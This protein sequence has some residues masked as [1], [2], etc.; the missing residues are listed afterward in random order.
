MA[1]RTFSLNEW[2]FKNQSRYYFQG[3]KRTKHLL[4]DLET[5]DYDKY[6]REFVIGIQ[7]YLHHERFQENASKWR[8]TR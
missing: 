5:L 6:I 7:K 8:V 2:I 3:S 1:G 4:W